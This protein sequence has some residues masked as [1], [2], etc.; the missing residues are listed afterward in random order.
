MCAENSK[1][2]T[3]RD[4]KQNKQDKELLKDKRCQS[5]I[6]IADGL[7]VYNLVVFP[8]PLHSIEALSL[9]VCLQAQPYCCFVLVVS[10]H[11][12]RIA[13]YLIQSTT[14]RVV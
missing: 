5:F 3:D 9:C 4:L 2:T 12:Y 13:E 8:L 11:R 14:L 7:F 10:Y 6:I 1:R